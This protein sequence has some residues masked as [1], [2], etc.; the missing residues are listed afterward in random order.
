MSIL[1][2]NCMLLCKCNRPLDEYS[3]PSDDSFHEVYDNYPIKIDYKGNVLFIPR[4][5]MKSDCLFNYERFPYDSQLCQ[6]I[7]IFFNYF[8]NHS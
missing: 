8:F 4:L 6:L 2:N 5:H 1:S 7:V 3:K